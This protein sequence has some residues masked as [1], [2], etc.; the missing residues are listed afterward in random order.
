MVTVYTLSTCPWCKR[1]KDFLNRE[2]I[3][4]DFKD[5]DVLE[6]EAKDQ[7]LQEIDALVDRRAFPITVVG[8]KVIQGFRPEEI[9]EAVDDVQ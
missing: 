1:L 5:V 7:A 3:D 2:K 4:Y 8:D 6:G 9:K